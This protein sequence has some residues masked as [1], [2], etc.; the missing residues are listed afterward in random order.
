MQ[1]LPRRT[2]SDGR[3]PRVRALSRQHSSH[4]IVIGRQASRTPSYLIKLERFRVIVRN[5]SYFLH[6]QDS[7]HERLEPTKT[8]FHPKNTTFPPTKKRRLLMPSSSCRAR[9]VTSSSMGEGSKNTTHAFQLRRSKSFTLVVL[10]VGHRVGCSFRVRRQKCVCDR[11]EG[12][13]PRIK[14]LS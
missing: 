8:D 14:F 9:N 6:P 3:P 13:K 10:E 11:R 5:V 7:L 1:E 12:M 2:R 4:S